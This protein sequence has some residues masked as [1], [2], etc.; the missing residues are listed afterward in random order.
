M[1][2]DFIRNNKTVD[3]IYNDFIEGKLIIDKSYQRRKVW[4]DEDKVRLIE[5]ILLGLVMPEVFF[6]VCSVDVDTGK[7][8]THIVDGQQRI[9]TIAEFISGKFVLNEKN[10]LDDEIKENYGGKSFKDLDEDAKRN[11]WQYPISVVEIDRSCSKEII[12]KMFNRLNL[13]N[14]CLNPQEKR[15]SIDSSFGDKCEALASLDFWNKN[16]VFSSSDAKRMKD[17]EYCCSIY[18]LAKE[19][20]VDQTN[21]KIINNYYDDYKID[22]DADKVLE[23]KIIKSMDIISSLSDKSTLQFVSKK[24]QMYTLFC[25]AFDMIDEKIEMNNKIFEKFKMFVDTYNKF[26]NEFNLTYDDPILSDVFDSIKKYKL[27]S[28]EGINKLKN[29]MIRFEIIKK[30]CICS[31]DSII[32]SLKSVSNNLA[33]KLNSKKMS[34]DKFEE[35]DIVDTEVIDIES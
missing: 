21:G 12:K 9:R 8:I 19:G 4:N 15:N 1:A 7:T 14:Y 11:I 5:T 35:D 24:A 3:V 16:K 29:R 22:F 18:I 34:Y 31:D 13:T 32:E 6:W 28:S 33:E 20:I 25:M 17:I 26:R 23:N 10:L 30:V 2:Y 27:A